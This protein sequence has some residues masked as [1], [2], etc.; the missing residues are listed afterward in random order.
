MLCITELLKKFDPTFAKKWSCP[1]SPRAEQIE[2]L[3]SLM[4]ENRKLDKEGEKEYAERLGRR[5]KYWLG[6]TRSLSPD[7]IFATMRQA[8]EGKNPGALFNHILKTKKKICQKS[9]TNQKSASTAVKPKRT[10]SG[11]TTE[12]STLFAQ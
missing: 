2:R 1:N 5:F 3:L 9:N 10:C 4:G 8:K 12:Q 7:E 11:S 6:R